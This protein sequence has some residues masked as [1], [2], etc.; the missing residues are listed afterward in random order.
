MLSACRPIQQ[1]AALTNE[2][3]RR[4]RFARKGDGTLSVVALL[5]LPKLLFS[6]FL[7]NCVRTTDLNLLLASP[8]LSYDEVI[9]RI[10][11]A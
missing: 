1:V 2:N 8:H 10:G 7:S 6:G 11:A 5:F 4:A 9:Q 3:T